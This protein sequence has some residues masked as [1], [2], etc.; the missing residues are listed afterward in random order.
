[1]DFIIEAVT[2]WDDLW[3][4]IIVAVATIVVVALLKTMSKGM[5]QL[6]STIWHWRG[7]GIIPR[8][9]RKAIKSYRVRRAKDV[10]LQTLKEPG[11][12]VE[13]R[14]Q[15]Y[16]N[17]LRYAPSKSTRSQLI[18]ITPAKPS[19]LNDYYVAT[20]LESLSNEGKVVKA[21]R[22]SINSWPPVPENYHFGPV[23]PGR[24]A[25]EEAVKIEKNDMCLAYQ[26]FH[27]CSK[28]PRFDSR[29]VA[30]TISPSKTKIKYTYPL[31]DAAPPCDLCW[32]QEG[33]ERDIRTLVDNITDYDLVD[34]AP[35]AITG[36][37]RELQ[38]AVSNACIDMPV[39]G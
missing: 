31:K 11:K 3:K 10:M 2:R 14:I 23:R 20:A 39:Q 5:Y 25:C 32:E 22:H 7:W 21:K 34:M 13:I 24:S 35:L 15:V 38:E 29:R 12:W 33:R 27:Y 6:G 9:C 37:N 17:C 16:D 4:A 30:E 8:H 1:M 26:F 19:W 18:A 28:P 36:A